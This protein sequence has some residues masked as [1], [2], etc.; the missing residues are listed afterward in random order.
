MKNIKNG[1][2]NFVIAPPGYTGKRYRGKYCYE[3]HYS[4]WMVH[5]VIPKRG[6]IIHHVDH[7]Q[8]NN[9]PHNLVLMTVEEHAREH[10][11]EAV[12]TFAIITCANCKTEVARN[13]AAVSYYIAHGRTHFFCKS[14][15]IGLYNYPRKSKV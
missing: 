6:E 11:A 2:Y 13:W 7:N 14:R 5:G 12:R 1:A 10:H 9:D 3:H 15:C 4:Y 8:R